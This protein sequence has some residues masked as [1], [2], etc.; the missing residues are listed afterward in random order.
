MFRYLLPIAI[1]IFSLF[2]QTKIFGQRARQEV[3]LAIYNCGLGGITSGVGAV[4]NKK[5]NEKP[6]RVFWRGFKYGTIGGFFNYTGKKITH[7]ISFSKD[8]FLDV[9]NNAALLWGWPAKIIH[10]VGSSIME[11]AAA[12][13]EKIF[14]HY[15]IQIGFINLSIDLKNHISVTP[16]LMPLSFLE[17]TSSTI[18]L[19][20]RLK[21]KESILLGTPYFITN[22][23]TS[24]FE[25]A[26]AE[27]VTNCIIV[28]SW[29]AS[30]RFSGLI[31]AHEYV[32]VLQQREYFVFNQYL[33]KAFYNIIN[34]DKPIVKLIN[35]HMYPDIPYLYFFYSIMQQ[36]R[37]T[38][39]KNI[40]ELE[41][42]HF[43]TNS[44]IKR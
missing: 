29:A 1:I 37:E 36:P 14:S 30:T 15:N 23:N 31:L 18:R 43:A 25:S 32:H 13:K 39:Y 11:N 35:K 21:F 28:K 24:Y 41:A 22:D 4:I 26:D 10:S 44:Y 5:K 20:S 40:F 8:S 7:L 27:A 19:G 33:R 38:Y 34:Q 42:E 12:N 2:F 16:Q 6:L 17:F 3:G 9:N